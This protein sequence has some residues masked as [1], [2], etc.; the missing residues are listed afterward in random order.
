MRFTLVI[1]AILLT[2]C[3]AK[4]IQY[5]LSGKY[6][7][8]PIS[9][10]KN[11]PSLSVNNFTYE[12]HKNISQYATSGF[13]CLLCNADGS[14][15]GFVY[16]QP[17]KDIIES[18]VQLAFEEVM[19]GKETNKCSLS[20][21]IHAVGWDSI[22]GDTTVDLTYILKIEKSAEYIKRIK[23]VYDAGIFEFQKVDKFWA[24][25]TRVT[26]QQLL[27]DNNFVSLVNKK[28]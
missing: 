15:R 13:G 1:F 17:V 4:P 26:V 23:G 5:D 6:T 25:P 22:N 27:R 18:E 20:G 14:F 10:K 3:A 7:D 12:P 19:V 2:G 9:V 24:K 21:Q 28:C 8:S 16:E 11:I